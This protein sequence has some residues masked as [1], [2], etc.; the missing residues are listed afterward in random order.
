MKKLAMLSILMLAFAT[1]AS[2]QP[3][4]VE[5]YWERLCSVKPSVDDVR[6][7]ALRPQGDYFATI[8]RYAGADAIKLFDAM[9]GH[10]LIKRETMDMTGITPGLYNLIEGAWADDGA[11]YAC[12][13]SYIAGTPLK[14]YRWATL[15]AT[16]VKIFDSGAAW[17]GWRL[18]DA[19]DAE[20]SESDN[21]AKIIISGNSAT[22]RPL[23]L[24]TTDNGAT[25]SSASLAN[26]VQSLEID[27]LPDGTFWAIGSGQNIRK[28]NADGTVNTTIPA[29]GG[30]FGIAYDAAKN[31]IYAMGYRENAY[32]SV[33]DVA[34]ATKVYTCA[35]RLDLGGFLVGTPN[36]SCDV[37]IISPAG[38][39][40]IVALSERNGVAKYSV[41]SVITV[42]GAGVNPFTYATVQGAIDSYCVGGPNAGATDK[43]LIIAIDPAAGPYDEALDLDDARV[44]RGNIAGDLV[45]R[46]TTDVAKPVLKLRRGLNA[47]DDGIWVYQS[48]NNVVFKDLVFCPSQT[49]TTVTDDL[50]KIDENAASQPSPFNWV[51]F[52]RCVVTNINASG[53]PMVTSKAQALNPPPASGSALAA[54]DYLIKSWG[55][56]GE[57][58]NV[59]FEE[60]LVYGGPST[61]ASFYCDGQGGEQVY[62]HN[63]MI[64][65]NGND[66]FR[67]GSSVAGGGASAYIRVSGTDAGAGY[68][69]CTAGYQNAW[70][71]GYFPGVKAGVLKIDNYLGYATLAGDAN[72]DARGISGSGWNDLSIRDSIISTV[73]V[74][75]VDGVANFPEYPPVWQ[76]TTFNSTGGALFSVSSTLPLTVS[77]CIFSGT[78]STSFTG[79]LTAGVNVSNS[80]AV[81]QGVGAISSLGAAVV[82]SNNIAQNPLYASLD[83]S[84]ASFLD[85]TNGAY[86]AVATGGAN[87]AGGADYIGGYAAAQGSLII[88]EILDGPLAG[89]NPKYVEVTAIKDCTLSAY[90]IGVE[91]NA[92]TDFGVFV[93]LPE[94]ALLAGQAFVIASTSNDG[95]AQYE[96]AF[97]VPADLYTSENF[98]NGDD[99][100]AVLIAGTTDIV[101]LHGEKGVDGTGRPWE[102]LDSRAYR[103]PGVKVPNPTFDIAEWVT[104]PIND[105]DGDTAQAV[106]AYCSPGASGLYMAAAVQSGTGGLDAPAPALIYSPTDGDLIN[107][108]TL[109]WAG[110]GLHGAETSSGAAFTNG[111]T[112]A[113]DGLHGLLADANGNGLPSSTTFQV[114]GVA[115]ATLDAIRIWAQNNDARQ[116]VNVHV[117]LDT[118]DDATVNPTY[119][120]E[121]INGTPGTDVSGTN[122]TALYLT[123]SR[124]NL[125][126]LDVPVFNVK[127]DFFSSG[128]GTQ[129]RG[130]GNAAAGSLVKEIDVLG[131]DLGT[132]VESWIEY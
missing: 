51:E 53:D 17:M 15:D 94:V 91:F 37:G 8:D 97:G 50:I 39:T 34:S 76:R 113:A 60:S 44:G 67:A 108:V 105:N 18:G 86:R 62:I 13:L 4:T 111:L 63:S 100:Y 81:K 69:Q 128:F 131:T 26:A 36:G 61:G 119:Y 83:A 74:C 120:G 49:A 35:D 101:D 64:A 121:Y 87:L 96:A 21:S 95:Q 56:P 33:W 65:W 129:I 48:V 9:T 3:V 106:G 32:L 117:Y 84:S 10:P 92:N 110:N 123:D 79:T 45:I 70:H 90:Q 58:R 125:G 7:L 127:L 75:V 112:D 72:G 99:R 68:A 23:I 22:S 85:V 130:E 59:L 114:G 122:W 24:S 31:W 71:Q 126:G 30:N 16:P 40:W 2:A 89:G 42:D 11:F 14:V 80:A 107:G 66:G 102:Y 28:F 6:N 55:D 38:G 1:V 12:S 104:M 132:S 29:S 103:K 46:S 77:D 25:W 118:T 54:S 124:G 88:T 27:L 5:K 52:Y 82:E 19:L 43:P 20:G 73:A 78:N 115:G 98:S 93:P 116:V 41:S 109:A 57:S 47:T